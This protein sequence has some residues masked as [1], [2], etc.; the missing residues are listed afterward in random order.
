L[1]DGVKNKKAGTNEHLV[2]FARAGSRVA[3]PPGLQPGCSF[4][5]FSD[6]QCARRRPPLRGSRPAG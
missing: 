2:V 3:E 4:D 6:I 5:S 1:V